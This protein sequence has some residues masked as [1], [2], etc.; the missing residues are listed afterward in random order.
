MA[1]SCG[2]E[3][4]GMGTCCLGG[5]HTCKSLMSLPRKIMYSYTSSLGGTG[6]S[7][8]RSSVPNDLT[9]AKATVDSLGSIV[10]KIPSYRISA[11]D[12]RLILL[13]KYGMPPL[14]VRS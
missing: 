13:P 8:G 3:E 7:V 14:M 5:S 6:L 11:F 10:Y 1:G 9:L 12:I 2:K 4:C